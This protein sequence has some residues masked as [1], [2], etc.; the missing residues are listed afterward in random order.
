MQKLVNE[1]IVSKMTGQALS[2]LRNARSKGC[3]IPYH[4]LGRSIRYSLQDVENYVARHRI[5]T[6]ALNDR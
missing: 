3:G 5:D 6:M 2:T 4:K 1:N